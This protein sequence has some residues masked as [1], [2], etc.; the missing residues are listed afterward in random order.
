[1]TN[2]SARSKILGRVGDH[3]LSEKRTSR[4]CTVEYL[5]VQEEKSVIQDSETI[6]A[7][8]VASS[9]QNGALGIFHA[10]AAEAVLVDCLDAGLGPRDRR[11]NGN[12]LEINELRYGWLWSDESG[13]IDE[14]MLA[15]P[16]SG[17][18]IL[19]SHGGAAVREA[20]CSFFR[21]RRFA[22][23]DEGDREE[24]GA[25]SRQD[26]LYDRALADCVTETQ[27]AAAL[28]ARLAEGGGVPTRPPERLMRTHR[29]LLA[30]PP[31]A[32]KSSFLNRMAGYDRAF[33]D[34]A[35]GATRDVVDE[36]VDIAGFAVRLGD[37][38]GYRAADSG[39]AVAAWEKARELLSLADAVWFVCDRSR[40]WKGDCERAAREIAGA[41]AAENPAARVS[42]I[43]NKSDLP[44]AW[45][46]EPWREYFPDARG[47]ALCSLP[48]GDALDVIENH[49]ETIWDGGDEG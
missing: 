38:P 34:P 26:I 45:T 35:A 2:F 15:K 28:E 24:V 44:P 37:L 13:P 5:S 12:A 42:V 36:L 16:C 6:R 33:V 20:V 46:D 27:V 31:N 43:M 32:G 11:S 49:L 4:Q 22:E 18:R 17:M 30:G 1:M 29:V 14:V 3:L 19:M 7:Y 21:Q 25:I 47:V 10:Y 48:D 9:R 40:E 41:L 8:L 23:L 39:L